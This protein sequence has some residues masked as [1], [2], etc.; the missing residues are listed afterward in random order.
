MVSGSGALQYGPQFGGL[1]DYEIKKPDTS[2][3]ISFETQQTVGSFG[4]FGSFNAIGGK[5]GK[6]TYYG[7]Y[8]FRRSE[9]WRDNS[10]YHFQAWHGSLKYD[11][12]N[13]M[14]LSA[15]Y[16]TWIM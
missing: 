6:L 13:S 10:D 2:K 1:L 4:L 14:Y 12:S 11:F 3:T 8:N 7:Y 15:G 5:V 9:G 16:R